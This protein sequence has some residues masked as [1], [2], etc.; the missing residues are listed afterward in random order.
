MLKIFEGEGCV[1]Y[2]LI[3]YLYEKLKLIPYLFS[4]KQYENHSRVLHL[5]IYFLK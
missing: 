1:Y 5:G 2:V 4:Q 3:T